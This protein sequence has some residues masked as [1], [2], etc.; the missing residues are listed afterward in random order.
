MF[1]AGMMDDNGRAG[2]TASPGETTCN[3]TN[4]HN[5]FTLNS[6]GGSIIATSTMN[7]W[8]YDPLTTYSIS[9][10][11]EKTGFAL[12]GVG[13]E[14]LT[15][16]NANAGTITVTD[17]AHTQ[18]KSRVVS[19]VTRR[20][21]VHTLN[22]G[23]SQ[24]S[25]IFTFN[26]TSPDTTTGPV[27]MYFA[28]NAANSSG[29]RTGDYIYNSSLIISPSSGNHTGDLKV[30][31]SF[32][33]HPNPAKERV[34]IHFTLAKYEN[35]NIRLSDLQGKYTA[36]LFDENKPAGNYDEVLILPADCEA[37]LYLLSIASASGKACKK[38]LV[39]E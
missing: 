8:T 25:M 15:G 4:C 3:T 29:S 5:S 28:G 34:T 9:I 7:N 20:N 35:V 38:L 12:F 11:V 39:L 30:I 13:V 26:W 14:I 16:T 17:A 32:S 33:I 1:S 36:V 18:I 10:K 2:Y 6:G 19:G 31:D 24:D 23:A 22:G 21:L 27:T 37:G